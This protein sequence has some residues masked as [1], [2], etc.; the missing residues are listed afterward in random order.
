MDNEKSVDV[1]NS[2]IVINNDRIEGY[3]TAYKETEEGDL[4]A[5]FE[6]LG[7]TSHK[8][9]SALISEVHKLGGE[10]EEGT[11]TS[12]KFYRVWMD[13]KA[14][15]TN[16]DRK[17]I[18]SSCEFG[19]DFAVKTYKEAMESEGLSSDLRTLINDQ[20]TEIKSGHDIVK[21]LRDALKEA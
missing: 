17:A 5:L 21:S 19:E 10:V 14:A 3:D 12:G 6:K 1:L 20:Y 8:C 11:T 2:L 18:L 4:K 7:K 9:K 15:L 13:I 16:K